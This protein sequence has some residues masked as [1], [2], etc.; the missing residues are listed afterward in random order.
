MILMLNSHT[1][2]NVKLIIFAL[3]RNIWIIISWNFTKKSYICML[4]RMIK[5]EIL[6]K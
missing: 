2:R 4:H 3:F 6:T 1:F 5:H